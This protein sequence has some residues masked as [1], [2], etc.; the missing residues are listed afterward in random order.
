MLL[1]ALVG[2]KI[3]L[4]PAVNI[5]ILSINVSP[6]WLLHTSSPGLTLVW[7]LWFILAMAGA[8]IFAAACRSFIRSLRFSDAVTSDFS[9]RGGEVLGWWVLWVLAGRQWKIDDP[10]AALLAGALYFLGLWATL[11][12]MRWFAGHVELSGKSRFSFVG[13]YWELLGWEVLLA[14]SVLSIIGWAWVMAAM[15]RWMARSTRARDA[16]LRFHSTGGQILWRTA[17]AILFSIPVV[18][19]PWAWHWYV[20]WL[21]QSTTIEGQLAAAAVS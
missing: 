20:R 11:N 8:W 7:T 1:I 15:Y 5:R 13:T 9:G 6:P 4:P 14:I 18:T 10:Q 17:A 3:S 12:I 16:S 2:I 19:I 21:V